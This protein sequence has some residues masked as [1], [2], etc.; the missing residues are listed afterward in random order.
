MPSVLHDKDRVLTV[1]RNNEYGYVLRQAS[2]EL[3][4]DKEVVLAAVQQDGWV[5]QYAVEVL[6]ADKEIVLAAVMSDKKDNKNP[7]IGYA[8]L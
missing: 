6:R 1:I 7:V 2:E 5:L 3:K 4:A 8:R